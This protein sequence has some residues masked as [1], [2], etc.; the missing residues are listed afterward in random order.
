MVASPTSDGGSPI[1]RKFRD[2]VTSEKAKKIARN[3]EESSS[4]SF[5]KSEE[6]DFREDVFPKTN[7]Q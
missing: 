1:T 6:K 3:G 7:N 4:D 5:Q 2:V